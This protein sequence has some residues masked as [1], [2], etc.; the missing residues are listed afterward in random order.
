MD[1]EQLKQRAGEEF[2]ELWQLG[3]RKREPNFL[4]ESKLFLLSKLNELEKAAREEMRAEIENLIVEEM[5]ICHQ[6]NIST[7][8]LT[9]LITKIKN[10]TK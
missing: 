5:L 10:L 1:T 3:F 4:K 8:R 7:S 2:E 9:S 6:E